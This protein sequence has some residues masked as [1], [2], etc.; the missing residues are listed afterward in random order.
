MPP[1][2][3]QWTAGVGIRDF[4]L[5]ETVFSLWALNLQYCWELWYRY[6]FNCLNSFKKK[7]KLDLYISDLDNEFAE[8]QTLAD[9]FSKTIGFY[10]LSP[11]KLIKYNPNKT[12]G[13]GRHCS[14]HFWLKWTQ[15]LLE[16]SVTYGDMWQD[17]LGGLTLQG[18][19]GLELLSP[20][21]HRTW[22]GNQIP[23]QVSSFQ[24]EKE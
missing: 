1:L 7:T 20:T 18:T 23:P 9:G 11:V 5:F 16:M 24:A 17:Q 2:H 6:E 8:T 22:Q 10:H 19:A 3:I 4:L 12:R 15:W 14:F 21:E 13:M